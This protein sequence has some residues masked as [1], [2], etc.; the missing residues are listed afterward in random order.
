MLIIA[1]LMLNCCLFGALFLPLPNNAVITYQDPVETKSI[2][3]KN[4]TI[5]IEDNDLEECTE[6]KMIE[7]DIENALNRSS[8]SLPH[9]TS[10]EVQPSAVNL[11]KSLC[12]VQLFVND[13]LMEETDSKQR[14]HSFSPGLLHRKDMFYSGSLVNIDSYKSS[15]EESL[16]P[17]KRNH[18]EKCFLFQWLNCSEDIVDSFYEMVDMTLLR[19]PIFLIFLISNFLTSIGYHVP[20]I[21]LKVSFYLMKHIIKVVISRVQQRIMELKVASESDTGYFTAIIG[22]S[23]TVSRLVF[24][25]LSDHSFVNRLWLYIVS[26]TLCGLVIMASSLV[27][28][29]TAMATFCALFG[30][31]C[32]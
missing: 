15:G 20:Y 27:F 25:Y 10:V 19:N 14:S 11:T 22:I 3:S 17:L 21:F 31:T 2:T 8:L 24:G 28:N 12:S 4:P 7:A 18:K 9:N 1:G 30:I 13:K 32:G 29:Y 5:E 23:S 6:N 16:Y 26:V